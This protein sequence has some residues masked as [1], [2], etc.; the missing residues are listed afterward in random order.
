MARSKRKAVRSGRRR[1]AARPRA[2][3]AARGPTEEIRILYDTVRDL[4]E[5]EAFRQMQ[6][7]ACDKNLKLIDIA[8][9]ILEAGP[10]LQMIG[11]KR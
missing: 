7:M 8:R 1:P 10:T 9:K 6:K 2:A 3:K 11:R 4:G 5:E